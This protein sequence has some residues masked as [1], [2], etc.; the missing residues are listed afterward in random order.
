MFELRELEETLALIEESLW[1][2]LREGSDVIRLEF[3]RTKML[4]IWLW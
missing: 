4:K 1:L 2:D 3:N